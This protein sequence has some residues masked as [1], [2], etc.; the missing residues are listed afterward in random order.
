MKNGQGKNIYFFFIALIHY[1]NY[2]PLIVIV[3]NNRGYNESC[4]NFRAGIQY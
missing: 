2:H 3:I 4:G 1:I